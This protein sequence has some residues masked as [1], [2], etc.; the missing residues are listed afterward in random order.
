MHKVAVLLQRHKLEEGRVDLGHLLM[1]LLGAVAFRGGSVVSLIGELRASCS[2]H[3][4]VAMLCLWCMLIA[5]D[6]LEDGQA[7]MVLDQWH[8]HH[9]LRREVIA[10]L[11]QR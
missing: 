10:S 9:V 2:D 5:V 3:L 7:A 4:V 6:R 11:G 8:E 1:L